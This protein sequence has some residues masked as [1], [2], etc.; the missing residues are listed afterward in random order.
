M[1][2]KFT[3]A[4]ASAYSYTT[5]PSFLKFDSTSY[6]NQALNLCRKKK[7]YEAIHLLFREHGD[8]IAILD[9][10]RHL[11]PFHPPPPTAYDSLF[12][13]CLRHSAFDA[14]K[15]AYSHAKSSGIDPG[16]IISNRLI[17][18][19]GNNGRIGDAR[20]VFDEM[21]SRDPCS[22]NALISGYVKGGFVKNARRVFDEMREEDRDS[23]SW[24]SMMSGYVQH[25]SPVKALM[26]YRDMKKG[27]KLES[28]KYMIS[29][30]LAA[31]TALGSLR[32]GKEIHGHI[33]RTGLI[34][35]PVV[36][37]TLSDMYAKCGCVSLARHVFDVSSGKDVVSWT[38][39][40]GWYFN[41][42]K[43]QEGFM[44]FS[45]MMRSDI[46][47]NEFTYAGIL[48]ACSNQTIEYAGKEVHGY[49]IRT[50]S[51]V[52]LFATAALIDMYSKCGNVCSA[53]NVFN[54]M[55]TP[56]VVSWSSIISCYAQNGKP[57]VALQHF[58]LMLKSGTKPDHIS[59]VG[60]L[61]A[62]M[63][64][65]LVERGLELFHSIVNDHE[66]EHTPDHYAC[67]VDLLSRAGLFGKVVAMVKN[68][69][70]KLNK[71]AWASLLNGCRIHRNV[72]F[73]RCAAEELFKIEPWNPATYVT[74]AN[75]YADA[76]RW[77]DVEKIRK[78]M[79]VRGIV[80]NPGSSWIKVKR[81][82][83]HFLV[84]DISHP[85]TKEIYSEL[86][87]LFDRMKKEGYIPETNFV[88]HDIEEEQKAQNLVHH[89]E[90]LA[91]A[92][93]IIAT[94]PCKPIKIFKNI[95]TCGDCHTAMK[96]ISRITRREII[97]RDAT[98]FHHFKDGM[99]TCRD[100]W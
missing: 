66:L 29:T 9:I 95:R 5:A 42:G 71:F 55:Q 68:L 72:T 62:C 26:L 1:M 64:A 84:N 6:R 52:C 48:N 81:R 40:M 82:L 3:A 54:G 12:Q 75:V 18:F 10:F 78:I 24:S 67:V 22:W 35:D 89:S 90:K 56:D 61:S 4:V 16:T 31:S 36:W 93:G 44:L 14:A 60:V 91:V 98:R 57:E 46:S 96:F 2:V 86:D 87:K 85:R 83:H 49:M 73:A 23:F 41:G 28:S 39:M 33:I 38:A 19:F 7:F 92:F 43:I 88:L 47:P 37:S 13:F 11:H 21:E 45:D 94:D 51:D 17:T 59:F 27:G 53:E 30:I 74:L 63:H 99:C 77:Y 20:N 58:E 32:C 100:Y 76:G 50:G 80:K 8:V 34:L 79:G 15:V 97:L 25:H 70:V 65:G 69:P